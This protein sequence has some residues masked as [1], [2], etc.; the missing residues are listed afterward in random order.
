MLDVVFHSKLLY[1]GLKYAPRITFRQ[2]NE[3]RAIALLRGRRKYEIML[4]VPQMHNWLLCTQR[5]VGLFLS[6][7]DHIW[8]ILE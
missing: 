2:E 5:F 3:Q 4:H 7:D 1:F 8:K 6:R